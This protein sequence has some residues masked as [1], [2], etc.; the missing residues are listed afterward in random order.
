MQLSFLR[1]HRKRCPHSLSPTHTQIHNVLLHKT[2]TINF[3]KLILWADTCWKAVAACCY[4]IHLADSTLHVGQDFI[5]YH[6]INFRE[7]AIVCTGAANNKYF[8]Y[9]LIVWSIKCQK[10]WKMFVTVSRSPKCRL[11]I[12]SSAQPTVQNTKTL[13][14]LSQ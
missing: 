4:V 11:Q 13:H 5:L 14:L 9:W 10:M 6:R 7:S 1:K 2:H 12:A 3:R 8:H